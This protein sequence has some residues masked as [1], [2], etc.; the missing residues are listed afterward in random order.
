MSSVRGARYDELRVWGTNGHLEVFP[1]PRVFTVKPT[2]GITASRWQDLGVADAGPYR[3]RFFE[4]YVSAVT[5]RA[6]PEVSLEDGLAVQRLIQA[7]Y[8]SAELGT[9]IDPLDID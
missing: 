4:Q 7:A 3:T 5:N 8:R 2:N 1:T 6:R 9:R